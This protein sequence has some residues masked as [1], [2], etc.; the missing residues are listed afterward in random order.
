MNISKIIES[1][2]LF[3]T[4]EDLA[5]MLGLKLSSASVTCNRYVKAGLLV[6]LSRNIFMLKEK[7]LNITSNER[8]VLANNLQVPSYISFTT[9][10]VFYELTTQLQQNY[11]ESAVIH[12]SKKIEVYNECFHYIKLKAPLYNNFVKLNGLF[13]AKPE[14]AFLDSLYLMSLGKYSLDIFSLEFDKLNKEE[15]ENIIKYYPV[16]TKN[17]WRDC[18][19]MSLCLQ[20]GCKMPGLC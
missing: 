12:R 10:L 19:E 7:F 11:T 15:I 9:A 16:K 5:V 2:K 3:F 18:C 1:N 8:Y 4:R 13:I 14:K 20:K 17:I 6:R